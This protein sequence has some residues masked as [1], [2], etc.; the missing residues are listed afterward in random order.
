M[1]MNA[2]H[3]HRHRRPADGQRQLPPGAPL[4]PLLVRVR[5]GGMGGGLALGDVGGAV[6]LKVEVALFRV[7]HGLHAG[8]CRRCMPRFKGLLRP[9]CGRDG[10]VVQAPGAVARQVFADAQRALALGVVGHVDDAA[11]VLPHGAAD[12]EAA[13]VEQ[14]AGQTAGSAA[15]RRGNR[16]R[17]GGR[18]RG[19]R[20]PQSSTCTCF[21]MPWGSLLRVQAVRDGLLRPREHFF[22]CAG[23]VERANAPRLP[24]PQAVV[25]RAQ[26]ALE[27]RALGFDAVGVAVRA[28]RAPALPP[29]STP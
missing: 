15:R 3:Q 21:H 23:A 22:D 4:A 26:A 17:S 16:G 29:S 6:F 1:T 7:L 5:R 9:G 8:A 10:A 12:Q 18:R 13:V 11:G 25:G 14:R 19:R 2:H 24:G 20:D 27:G 28:W